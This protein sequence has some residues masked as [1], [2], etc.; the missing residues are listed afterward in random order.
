MRLAERPPERFLPVRHEDEMHMV[1]HQAVSPACDA[2]L[3]APARQEIAIEFVVV[4]AEEHPLAPVAALGDV[5]GK[6]GDDEAGD[7]GHSGDR[8]H[9]KSAVCRAIGG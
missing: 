4:V 7:A 2:V 1:R 8:G 5:M 3:A 9:G 6:T